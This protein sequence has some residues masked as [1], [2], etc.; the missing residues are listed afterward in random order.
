[1]RPLHV[2]STRSRYRQNPFAIRIWVSL[3][4]VAL[5]WQGRCVRQ[6]A[7]TD[8]RNPMTSSSARS[9][10]SSGLPFPDRVR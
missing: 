10:L 2:P 1:M 9:V 3:R 5:Q 8:K 6:R 7:A 4:K